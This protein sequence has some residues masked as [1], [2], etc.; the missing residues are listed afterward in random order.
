M[1]EK[2]QAKVSGKV[3]VIPTPWKN[4]G[5]PVQANFWGAS[6]GIFLGEGEGGVASWEIT[7]HKWD[8]L[9]LYTLFSGYKMLFFFTPVQ[10]RETF[11][12]PGP[13][14]SD[15]FFSFDTISIRYLDFFSD[16]CLYDILASEITFYLGMY[17]FFNCIFS[18]STILDIEESILDT[19]KRF[20]IS[21]FD[22]YS[23]RYFQGYPGQS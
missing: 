23:I 19:V 3:N 1:I 7:L 10:L 14:L 16:R 11:V 20:E 18:V 5:M 13:P 12:C 6:Q 9:T 22:R 4:R 17:C 2:R 15:T 21:T 8:M